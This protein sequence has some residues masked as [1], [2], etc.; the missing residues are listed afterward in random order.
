MYKVVS[1]SN[2]DRRHP[3]DGTFVGTSGWYYDWNREKSLDWYVARS[4]LSSVEL[5]VSFYRFPFQEMVRTWAEKGSGLRWSVKAHRSITHHHRFNELAVER[6]EAFSER[7]GPMDHLID[8]YL[9][10]APPGFCD[11]DAVLEFSKDVGLGRRMAFEVRNVDLLMDDEL[12]AELMEDMTLVSVDSP[13]A[14]MRLL[15]TDPVYMRMHGRDDWYVHDY[16]DE[17]L[18]EVAKAISDKRGGDAYIF[19]NNDRMLRNARTMAERM[20]VVAG[21]MGPH[22]AYPIPR[23]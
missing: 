9:F 18:E 6:F 19:F 8:F 14:R 23:Q 10:Q 5:N 15:S 13:D 21:D 4:G 20:M 11:V 7:F 12:C 17:E 22:P 3:E 16:S 2:M 1:Q